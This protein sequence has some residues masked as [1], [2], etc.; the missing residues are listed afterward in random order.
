[1]KNTLTI[2][3]SRDNHYEKHIK[4]LKR[5]KIIFNETERREIVNDIKH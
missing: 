5:R 2:K 4:D 1:M 3:T